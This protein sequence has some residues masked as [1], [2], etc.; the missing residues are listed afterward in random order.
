MEKLIKFYNDVLHNELKVKDS[1]RIIL[2]FANKKS[3]VINSI[4]FNQ[5]DSIDF[6]FLLRRGE[7]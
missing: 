2:D 6:I 3:F 4:I 7:V 5:G 1:A